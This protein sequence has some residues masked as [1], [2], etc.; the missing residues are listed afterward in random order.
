MKLAIIGS[1]LIVNQLLGAVD[2]TFPFS[3]EVIWGREH[4]KEKLEHLAE[5]YGI[6]RI[7]YD[8]DEILD[9]DVEVVYIALLNPFHYEYTKKALEA[10]KHVILEKPFAMNL[11]ETQ[12]LIN[13]AK[14]KGC[15]LLEAINNQYLPNFD[16]IKALLP[17]A[18][19]VKLVCFN[20]SQYSTRYDRFKKGEILPVFDWKYG[21]G[22]LMDLNVYNIHLAVGLFGRP[23]TIDYF[24]NMEQGVDTSG[25]LVMQY[26]TF[27]CVCIAA[28]DCGA[29]MM[30]MIQGDRGSIC[31]PTAPNT[32][33]LVEFQDNKGQKECYRENRFEHRLMHEFYAFADILEQENYAFCYDML[34]QSRIVGEILDQARSVTLQTEK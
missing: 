3:L 17:K 28:K 34:E 2:Q 4:S 7:S 16:R 5:T 25:V 9:S 14:E 19:D 8:Y 23:E 31:I 22:A 29:P 12:E 32:L 27:Q 1:G 20:Y 18:G 33:E 13:L 21:G 10:G 11:A 24:P 15:M 6:K 30:N 26:R